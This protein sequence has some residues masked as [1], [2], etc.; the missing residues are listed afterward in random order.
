MNIPQISKSDLIG[1][2]S[3]LFVGIAILLFAG[4]LE[5]FDEDAEKEK[6]DETIEDAEK[7]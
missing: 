7:K 4:W 5:K 2:L 6:R 1:I 3:A